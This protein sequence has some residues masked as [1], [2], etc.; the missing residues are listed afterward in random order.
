MLI[1]MKQKIFRQAVLALIVISLLV[2]SHPAW[3]HDG[4]PR[5]EISSD[6][7]SPGSVLE[8]RGV[9]IAAEESISVTLV[10]AAG[11]LLLGTV[12]GNEHGD[13]TQAFALP[14]DLPEGIYEVLARSSSQW[15]VSAP[16]TITGPA[17]LVN[18]DEGGRREQAE[19]LLAPIPTSAIASAVNPT[20]PLPTVSPPAELS[21]ATIMIGTLALIAFAEV[22]LVTM[23]EWRK[24]RQS[25][26]G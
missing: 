17:V 3:A 24:R 7:L 16:L 15:V 5:V 18:E 11:A 13:F 19:P 25:I 8:V 14:V 2:G 22:L 23:I 10:G 26:S 4:D 1:V 12:T 20:P 6:R 9:N 21:S